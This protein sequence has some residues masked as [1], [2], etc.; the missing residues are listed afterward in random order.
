MLRDSI[1]IRSPGMLLPAVAGNAAAGIED[2]AAA[3]K[4]AEPGGR[5]GGF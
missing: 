4:P 3:E 2:A 5:Y 1:R